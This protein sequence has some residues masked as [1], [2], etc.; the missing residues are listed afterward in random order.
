MISCLLEAK[1]EIDLAYEQGKT[2][3]GEKRFRYYDMRYSR[4]LREG[5][6]ELRVLAPPEK[7]TRGRK[8]Q[9]KVENLHD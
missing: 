8:A 3:L 9:H 1:A 4:I 5:R 6:Q 2:A 7:V